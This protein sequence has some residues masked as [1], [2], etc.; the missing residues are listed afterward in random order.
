[1]PSNWTDIPNLAVAAG[2]PPRASV[3]TAM[4]DNI[5][6]LS[7]GA[8]GAPRIVRG[9]L[10]TAT[11]SVSGTLAANGTVTVA[12]DAWSFFPHIRG[13][14]SGGMAVAS[15]TN[16]TANADTPGF[17]LSNPFGSTQSYAVAWR[18]LL[19]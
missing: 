13:G 11:N 14:T 5:I 8:A 3:W 9:A 15:I 4:R 19:T 7:E 12:L 16:G 18:S 10:K 6:A 1:M 2:A 17:Q